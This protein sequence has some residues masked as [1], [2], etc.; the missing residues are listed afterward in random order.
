MLR[1]VSAIAFL[2]CL[3]LTRTAQQVGKSFNLTTHSNLTL[4]PQ[5]KGTS[6][7]EWRLGRDTKI[8]M[9]EKGYGYS[10]PSG[11]F[12]GRVE[13]NETSVTLF[14]LRPNDSAILTYFSEDSSGTESEYPYAISVRGEPFP[15]FAPF[16]PSSTLADTQYSFSDPLRPPILRLMTNNSRPRTESRI[17]LQCIALDNDS[18]ITYAWYTDTLESGDNIQQV[19]VPTDPE[20]AVT[21]RISDG[22]SSNSATLVVPL[23]RGQ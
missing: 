2:S 13:M 16:C 3:C 6:K 1:P 5:T 8:A 4:H 11:P 19:T 7:Q 17:S 21:C 14:D 15:T 12:K 10:Y 9:W 20:V 18:S 22:H 23:N